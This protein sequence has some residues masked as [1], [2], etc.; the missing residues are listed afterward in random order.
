MPEQELGKIVM[1]CCFTDVINSYV[2]G[3][4]NEIQGGLTGWANRT[5]T[6]SPDA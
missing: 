2:F 4:R 5:S 6:E 3:P 1:R